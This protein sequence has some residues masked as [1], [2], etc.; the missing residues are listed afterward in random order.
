MHT[1]L[2]GKSK[3][4]AIGRDWRYALDAAIR[5]DLFHIGSGHEN[6]MAK[7]STAYRGIR[8][9]FAVVLI[10]RHSYVARRHLKVGLADLKK[11][12]ADF[13]GGRSTRAFPEGS[14]VARTKCRGRRGR[15]GYGIG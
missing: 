7:R 1:D 8:D 4:L 11:F 3:G 6:E 14:V 10:K 9:Y 2:P 5:H 12:L 15:N 13:D